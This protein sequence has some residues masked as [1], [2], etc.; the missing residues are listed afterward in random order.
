MPIVPYI[1]E[2]TVYSKASALQEGATILIR[3]CTKKTTSDSESTN[4]SGFA[5]IDLAN[6]TGDT[7]YEI[8]DTILMIAHYGNTMNAV[9]YVLAGVGKKQTVYLRYEGPV[10]VNTTGSCRIRQISVSNTDSSTTYYAEVYD[11]STGEL[12]E[13]V[14]A[15]AGVTQPIYYGRGVGAQNGFV[16]F[17]ENVKLLV[18]AKVV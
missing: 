3:N 10:R 5:A 6:M 16:V 4:S 13:H 12:I 11:F 9:K 14:E 17:T 18:T 8:G 2:M 1:V 15:L 7:P